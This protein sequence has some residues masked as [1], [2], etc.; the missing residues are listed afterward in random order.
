MDFQGSPTPLKLHVKLGTRCVC[1]W[2]DN[3]YMLSFNSHCYGD[4]RGRGHE[5]RLGGEGTDAYDLDGA[6]A[7]E[8]LQGESS[9]PV[10]HFLSRVLSN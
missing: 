9:A 8:E 2:E 5:Q 7:K 1:C 10:Y 4:A 3:P 6:K